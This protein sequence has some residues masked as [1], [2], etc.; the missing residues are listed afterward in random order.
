MIDKVKQLKK[1]IESAEISDP[2][3]LEEFRLAYLSRKGAVQSMFG[4]MGSVPKED[5]AEMGRW[6]NQVKNLAEENYRSGKEA[7]EKT[8]NVNISP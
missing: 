4:L 7:L 3:S 6:M 8:E 5:R 2:E 1:E